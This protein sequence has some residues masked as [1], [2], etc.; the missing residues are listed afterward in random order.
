MTVTVHSQKKV[1]LGPQCWS[2]YPSQW[3]DPM[4]PRLIERPPKKAQP[5]RSHEA[6]K[7]KCVCESTGFRRRQPVLMQDIDIAIV[8]L[9]RCVAAWLDTLQSVEWNVFLWER[10]W[11]LRVKGWAV[12]LLRTTTMLQ[13]TDMGHYRA[14]EEIRRWVNK[15]ERKRVQRKKNMTDARSYITINPPIPCCKRI[16]IQTDNVWREGG[17]DKNAAQFNSEKA[18]YY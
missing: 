13:G 6:E 12:C 2:V 15:E 17:T 7:S 8:R 14:W 4:H 5:W 10:V 16:S 9:N 18:D 3:Q 11:R 1:T